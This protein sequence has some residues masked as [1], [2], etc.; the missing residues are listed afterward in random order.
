MSS[1]VDFPSKYKDWSAN[2]PVDLFQAPIVKAESNPKVMVASCFLS[3][4]TSFMSIS[5]LYG[6]TNMFHAREIMY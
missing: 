1:S 4:Y 6:I 3:C 2:D 5:K